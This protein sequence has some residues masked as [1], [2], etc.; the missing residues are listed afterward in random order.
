MGGIYI[1]IPFC[2]QACTYC[3]FH[4]STSISR[5][6]EMVAAIVQEIVLRKHEF[7]IPIQTIYFGGGTPGIL[8]LVALQKIVDAIKQCANLVELK[9]FT[10]EV[11]PDDMNEAKLKGLLDMG[12]NRLSVGTQSFYKEDLLFMNRSHDEH[13]AI[14]C[15]STAQAVGF[16]NISIDLIYGYPLLTDEK[17][18]NNLNMAKQ[19]GVSHISSYA[20]TVEAKTLLAHQ[21]KKKMTTP[22]DQAQAAHQF[23][24]LMQWAKQNNIQHY[25]IS[26]FAIDYNYALH[27]TNYW[28][29]VKYIGIGP[30]AHSYNGKEVRQWNIAHN[31][32]YIKSINDGK[33]PI[34]EEVLSSKDIINESIMLGLRTQWGVHTPLLQQRMTQEQW[35][36]FNNYIN[37]NQRYF[38]IENNSIKLN[39]DGKLFADRIASDLFVC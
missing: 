4:F 8:S 25:E 32:H 15:I 7:N 3:N 18:M 27:N 23:Q 30:S 31:A 14:N 34:T 1:H 2:K 10:I 39:D 17:W 36:V 28:K 20:L 21:I 37:T 38:I 6:S 13:S 9:E 24:L 29:G 16:K 35:T 11:N 19:M 26:N 33:L 22:L 12:C 5:A